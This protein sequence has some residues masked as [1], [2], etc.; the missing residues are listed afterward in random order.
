MASSEQDSN[1]QE[2]LRNLIAMV[3]EKRLAQQQEWQ[4]K[5]SEAERAKRRT[6]V[7]SRRQQQKL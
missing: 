7:V 6:R 4:K 1:P 2:S 5:R 3:A